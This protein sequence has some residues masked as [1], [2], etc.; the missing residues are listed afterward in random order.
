ME[1]SLMIAGS[2]GQGILACGKI[3][4]YAGMNEQL[5]VT[6]YPSYGAEVRGGTTRC[7]VKFSDTTIASPIVEKADAL[8][9]FNEPSLHKYLPY[10][11]KDGLLVCN[12]SLIHSL[13]SNG[14]YAVKTVPATSLAIELGNEKV[15]NMIMSGY[16]IETCAFLEQESF[17]Q[18]VNEVFGDIPAHLKSL[19]ISALE[20]GIAYARTQ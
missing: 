5:N 6:Y 2:G 12:S 17:T 4:A 16:F 13:P 7:G 11:K 18:A 8:V 1:Y 14:T 20:K 3:F 10:L 9:V 19:N 15:C